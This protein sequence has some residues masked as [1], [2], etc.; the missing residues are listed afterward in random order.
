VIYFSV[1]M[2]GGHAPVVELGQPGATAPTLL[3]RGGLSALWEDTQSLSGTM[4][5]DYRVVA[6]LKDRG[7]VLTAGS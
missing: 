3:K 2:T 7:R 5:N 6:V 1:M 4:T